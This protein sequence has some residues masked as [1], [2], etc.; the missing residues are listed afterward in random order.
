MATPIH[1]FYD[2][3]IEH[4]GFQEG[5]GDTG[6]TIITRHVLNGTTF[7]ALIGHLTSSS[8]A[9]KHLGMSFSRG[10]VLGWVGD[11]L[12]RENGGWPPHVHFQLSMRRPRTHDLPGVVALADLERAMDTFPDPRLVLGPIYPGACAGVEAP[13]PSKF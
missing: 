7:F 13:S 11:S 9:Y 3:W 10:E 5:L 1:A 6:H 12:R 2:G 4:F 8:M